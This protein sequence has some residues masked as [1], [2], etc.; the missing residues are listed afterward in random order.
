M[1]ILECGIFLYLQQHFGSTNALSQTFIHKILFSVFS[2]LPFY[3]S[4][5]LEN[6]LVRN[7]LNVVLTSFKT[8]ANLNRF[9]TDYSQ[10]ILYSDLKFQTFLFL[11]CSWCPYITS[12]SLALHTYKPLYHNLMSSYLHKEN[13]ILSAFTFFLRALVRELG[14]IY[15]KTT[16][17]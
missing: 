16:K 8:E 13:E 7:Q 17:D 4:L 15:I 3:A 11:R 5:L 1:K 12:V 14:R 10:I 6:K 9:R 2:N